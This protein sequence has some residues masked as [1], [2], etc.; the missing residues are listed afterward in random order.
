[1]KEDTDSASVEVAGSLVFWE[2]TQGKRRAGGQH[3]TYV[4]QLESYQTQ[5]SKRGEY[6]LKVNF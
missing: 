5:D 3:Y 1:M 4:D 6:H 2:P